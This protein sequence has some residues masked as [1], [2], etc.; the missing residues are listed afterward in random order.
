MGGKCVHATQ[1]DPAVQLRRMHFSVDVTDEGREQQWDCR[2]EG[3]NH[4]EWVR[5]R[6]DLCSTA[7]QATTF[8]RVVNA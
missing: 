3:G 2:M 1:T 7:V 8:S 4:W 5:K 6:G